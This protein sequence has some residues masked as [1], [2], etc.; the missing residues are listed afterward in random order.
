MRSRGVLLGGVLAAVLLVGLLISLVEPGQAGTPT[1]SAP[2]VAATLDPASGLPMVTLTSLP[3]E[4]QRTV[5]LIERGGPFPYAKDGAIFGNRERILPIKP[6]GFYREY[7]VP[8]PGD[9]DRGPRRLVT[10]DQDQQLFYTDDHYAS[11]VRVAR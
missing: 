7:T 1:T 4:A 10:G 3:T 11:F 9:D 2:P 6:R 8:T 5:A